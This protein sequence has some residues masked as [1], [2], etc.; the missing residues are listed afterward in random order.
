[1]ELCDLLEEQNVYMANR[2][3]YS[4]LERKNIRKYFKDKKEQILKSEN[5]LIE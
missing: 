2:N 5:N 3:S 1:M 4:A